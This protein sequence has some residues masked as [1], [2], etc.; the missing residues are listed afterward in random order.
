[1]FFFFSVKG[2]VYDKCGEVLKLNLLPY[3]GADII[4]AGQFEDHGGA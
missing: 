2:F 1:M 4:L 3:D